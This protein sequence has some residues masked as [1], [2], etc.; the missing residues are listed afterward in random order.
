MKRLLRIT[1]FS[2]ILQVT[3]FSQNFIVNKIEPANWWTGMKLNKIQLM[4]YG[5]NLKDLSA[6][7]DSPGISVSQIHEIENT[8]YCFIDIEITGESEAQIYKLKLSKD[9]GEITV[10]FPLFERN[11]S[12]G[13][14]NGF[15]NSDVIYLITPDRFANGDISNDNVEGMIEGCDEDN[16]LGRHGGDI[17]GIIDHLDYL[18]YLGISAIWVNPLVENNT[19]ISYHGYAATDFYNIDPRFGS[20]ELYKKFVDE[21]HK[22]GLKIILDHVSNHMSIDHPWMKD[23]PMENWIHGSV[24]NHLPAMHHKMVLSDIH[25]EQLAF[26]YLQ[27]GWFVDSM[28][29]L[30]QTN[31]FVANYI[32]QNTVWW[33][34]STGLDGIR[35]DTYPYADQKFLSVWAKTILEE[36]PDLNI[37]GEVWT[38][39][40]AFLA[41][42]QKNS[43]LPRPFDSYLPSVTDF[44]FQE[45]VR[46]YLQGN[47][48]LYEV[49]QTFAMDYLYPDPDNFVTFAD[50]HDIARIMF[51][52]NGNME[53]VKK[54]LTLLFTTRGIPQMLYATEIGMKGT[55]D[56]G[57]LRS[58]F[59]GG[60]PGDTRNAFEESGRTGAENDIYNFLKK[61]LELRKKYPSLS[62]GKFVQL[63]PF[64][65]MYIYLKILGN[66]KIMIILN[67][68]EKNQDINPS[69]ILTQF[70]K[71]DKIF[72]LF[73]ENN[74]KLNSAKEISIERKSIKVLLID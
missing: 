41:Y 24:E 19:H 25:G 23:L 36:Y 52:S 5:E 18:K 20:N 60:F 65:D 48:D 51:T 37:V 40:P 17:Q 49:Y 64:D 15:S 59:P 70:G 8:N 4:V 56:H 72:D 27:K 47:A 69:M 31:P 28:P 62:K 38:G 55:E 1:L 30:D 12:D 46:K 68:S 35:E 2:A 71:Y 9:S 57:Y 11:S 3:V 61:L 13:I 44:G 53:K 39:I 34:E 74:I 6:E 29:D 66:E 7:F 21:A 42:Y 63:P 14:H 26:D 54:V 50:N 22:R 45:A 58:N 16:P 33:V 43:Y 10:D 32:I 73:L 67:D